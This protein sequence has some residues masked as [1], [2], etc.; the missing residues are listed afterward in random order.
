MTQKGPQRRPAAQQAP[1]LSPP[2]DG[3]FIPEP[4]GKYRMMVV[5][6][7]SSRLDIER[8]KDLLNTTHSSIVHQAVVW[9][10]RHHPLL[11]MM[12]KEEEERL[13]IDDALG[14]VQGMVSDARAGKPI[15]A[16]R[17]AELENML[18][19]ASN[20]KREATQ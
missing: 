15:G 8:A 3:D 9:F 13:G 5:I 2:L 6:P 10:V 7:H 17:L 20:L 14:T 16:E 18:A 12:R 1:D 4:G 19:L 11:L